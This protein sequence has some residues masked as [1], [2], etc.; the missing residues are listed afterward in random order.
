M[1]AKESFDIVDITTLH[2]THAELA[3]AAAETG[4]HVVIEKPIA[5][6]VKEADRMIEAAKKNNIK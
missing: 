5:R 2:G 1:L 6:T 3:I 4:A